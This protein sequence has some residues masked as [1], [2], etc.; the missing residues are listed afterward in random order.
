MITWSGFGGSCFQKDVLNLVYLCEAL[1]LPEVASYWQQV[2]TAHHLIFLVFLKAHTWCFCVHIVSN[3]LRWSTWTNIKDEDLPVGLL[4]AS[5]T[6]LLVKRSL[7]WASHSKKTQVTPGW[8]VF[9]YSFIRTPSSHPI[10]S[11]LCYVNHKFELVWK[12]HKLQSVTLYNLCTLKTCSV[13]TDHST[14]C[15]H[16]LTWWTVT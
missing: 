2:R 4:T 6:L 12:A 7:C 3:S 10:T 13:T 16:L 8:S 15:K 1:N 9:I 5:S 14:L 11:L